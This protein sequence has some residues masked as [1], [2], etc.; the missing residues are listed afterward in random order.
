LFPS[1]VAAVAEAV[2][3]DHVRSAL[4]SERLQ[5]GRIGSLRSW[6][7]RLIPEPVRSPA[8]LDPKWA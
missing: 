5:R 2:P 6:P 4:R 1:T 3:S 7:S 8:T